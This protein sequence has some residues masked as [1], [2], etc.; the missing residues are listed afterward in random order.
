[1]IAAIRLSFDLRAGWPVVKSFIDVSGMAR[2]GW[3]MH[4]PSAPRS[5]RTGL[6]VSAGA[7]SPGGRW[8]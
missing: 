8:R 6:H 1:M 7:V 4:H 2:V 5:A 3:S